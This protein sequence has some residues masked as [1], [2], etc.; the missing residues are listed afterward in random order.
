MAIPEATL[1]AQLGKHIRDICAVGYA[2]DSDNHCAHFVS[3][4]LGYQFGATC[5]TMVNGTGTSG[6]IR[7]QELFSRC[8]SAGAWSGLAQTL[9]FGLVFI[10]NASNVNLQN[11]QMHNVPRKHVGIFIG[12][13][14][15][16]YHYSNSQR[17]VV[18]QTPAQFSNHY[19]APDNAM[20]W[21]AAP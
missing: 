15:N 8:T 20:F 9:Q 14:R 17:R 2:N 12:P 19:A 13:A 7:V 16:I 5:R 10:T 6:S 18:M 21:G 11:R 4:M 1:V 3:H